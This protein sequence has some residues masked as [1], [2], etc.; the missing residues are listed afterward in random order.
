[1]DSLL[2]DKILKTG[3]QDV[4]IENIVEDLK[5]EHL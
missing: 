3:F 1:M 4:T 2:D 5:N